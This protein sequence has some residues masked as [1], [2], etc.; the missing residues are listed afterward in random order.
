[1]AIGRA[2]VASQSIRWSGVPEANK[3][4]VHNAP[5]M[6]RLLGWGRVQSASLAVP[7]PGMFYVKRGLTWAVPETSAVSVFRTIQCARII[8]PLRTLTH[9]V[10]CV[11]GRGGVESITP[12][13]G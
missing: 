5:M 3:H 12:A 2:L 13:L 1:M 6:E 4:P 9:M 7:V 8:D 11:D 10:T